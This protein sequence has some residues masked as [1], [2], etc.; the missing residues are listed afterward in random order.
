MARRAP[1]AEAMIARQS[2][3]ERSTWPW[4]W[5]APRIGSLHEGSG[6]LALLPDD[7]A[8]AFTLDVP[9]REWIERRSPRSF[10]GAQI[11]TGMVPGAADARAV[12]D[13]IGEWPVI[14]AAMGVDRKDLRAR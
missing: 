3:N 9:D 14:M 4:G 11:E 7:N 10:P 12:H 1:S 2:A 8:V 13:A 5:S 6:L